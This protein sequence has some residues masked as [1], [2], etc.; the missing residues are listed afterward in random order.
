MKRKSIA[1]TGLQLVILLLLSVSVSS[2]F[3]FGSSS[4]EVS[5]NVTPA[6]YK[7]AVISLDL[8]GT[9]GG[10]SPVSTPIVTASSG[11]PTILDFTPGVTAGTVAVGETLLQTLIDGS[12]LV[13][14][15][16][17]DGYVLVPLYIEMTFNSTFHVPSAADDYGYDM[18]FTADGDEDD[19][20]Y[21][22]YYNTDTDNDGTTAAEYWKRD[23]VVKL[24]GI[25]NLTRLAPPPALDYPDGWYWM[26]RSLESPDTLDF[27][28][29]AEKTN[30]T[31][32]SA[33][34]GTPPSS[35]TPGPESV[36]D[37]FDDYSFWGD[38]TDYNDPAIELEIDSDTD[39]AMVRG[40]P[41][42]TYA[43][44][45]TVTAATDITY[46][47]NFWY[48]S[49][50]SVITWT[51]F[52]SDPDVIDFGPSYGTGPEPPIYGDWGFHPFLP[53]IEITVSSS[54]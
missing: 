14:G 44:G 10:G 19:Y 27:F 17:Y 7:I 20:T 47:V 18:I 38:V 24:E 34:P 32:P 54:K 52:A 11:S 21:R 15:A 36:I 6:S 28:I 13:D 43:S 31:N 33:H 25:P 42:F 12:A 1:V 3:L 39:T 48:E 35:L 51:T 16:T 23:I 41:S 46:T 26:R 49:D 45:D 5:R 37:Q 2:C 9:D 30:G 8:T 29:L 22:F 50:A 53:D 40:K 4:T